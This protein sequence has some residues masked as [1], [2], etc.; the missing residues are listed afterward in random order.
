MLDGPIDG[1]EDVAE[2]AFSVFVEHAQNGELDVGCDAAGRADDAGDVRPMPE[3]IA[4]STFRIDEIDS[5]DHARFV[6]RCVLGQPRVDQRDR[7]AASGDA[8][9]GIGDVTAHALTPAVEIRAD[10]P[11]GG[12]RQHL[13]T[14]DELLDRAAIQRHQGGAT[15]SLHDHRR[16]AG[17]ERCGE[18]LRDG[19]GGLRA[20]REHCC[21]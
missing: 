18:I 13:G 5:R 14:L 21:Q 19:R 11:V 7:H 17:L 4:S 20:G 10:D 3:A 15:F 6:D 9:A 1:V 2:S 16:D 12:D 8:V